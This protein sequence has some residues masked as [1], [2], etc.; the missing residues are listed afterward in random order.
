MINAIIVT[1]PGTGYAGPPGGDFPEPK[2]PTREKSQEE[3]PKLG[4]IWQAKNGL[5]VTPIGRQGGYVN[6]STSE[7]PRIWAYDEFWT[8]VN[9]DKAEMVG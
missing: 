6:L 7:G 3:C 2:D 1:N 8:W 9:G 4:S 5:T